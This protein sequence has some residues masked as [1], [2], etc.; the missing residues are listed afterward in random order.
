MQG[1][2]AEAAAS[3]QHIYRSSVLGTTLDEALLDLQEQYPHE[4]SH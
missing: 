2:V 3:R 4:I 1:S